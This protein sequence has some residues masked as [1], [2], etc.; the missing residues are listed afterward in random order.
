MAELYTPKPNERQLTIRSLIAGC[1]LG[2]GVCVINAYFGLKT[3]W[4]LSGALIAAI[5]GY[6]FFNCFNLKSPYS[7]LENN[8][9]ETC[10][11]AV[12][13]TLPAMG[14]V[15]ILPAMKMLGYPIPISG[16]YAWGFSTCFIGAF[17]QFLCETNLLSWINCDSLQEQ[18]PQK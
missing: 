1:I 5:F 7:V 16:M 12:S 18:P 2:S 9:T 6:L 13:M 3:G 8:I 4:G 10:G 15:T 14:V 17:L 11:S